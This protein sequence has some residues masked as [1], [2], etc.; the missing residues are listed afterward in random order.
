MLSPLESEIQWSVFLDLLGEIVRPNYNGRGQQRWYQFLKGYALCQIGEWEAGEVEFT[1]LRRADLP[2]HIL[3]LPRAYL[4]N[5]KGGRAT[6]QGTMQEY[7]GRLYL[8]V[9]EYV[10]FYTDKKDRWNA[11]GLIDHANIRFCFAGPRA[12]HDS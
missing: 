5:A 8:E 9:P 12:V 2:P 1:D 4:L 11:P 10:T 7:G 3:W 6:V